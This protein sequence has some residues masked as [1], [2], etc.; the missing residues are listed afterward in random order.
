MTDQCQVEYNRFFFNHHQ[1]SMI[2]LV[3]IRDLLI[4]MS[5]DYRQSELT[6][7]WDRF[8]LDFVNKRSKTVV[9]IMDHLFVCPIRMSD[10]T[11]SELSPGRLVTESRLLEKHS[12]TFVVC[13]IIKTCSFFYLT[14]TFLCGLYPPAIYQNAYCS[15]EYKTLG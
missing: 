6:L 10:F 8:R 4:L 7:S 3:Q 11:G 5:C 14:L 1:E 13:V 12:R 15:H 9:L 2:Y